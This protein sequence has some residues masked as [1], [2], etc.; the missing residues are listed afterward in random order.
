MTF[1]SFSVFNLYINKQRALEAIFVVMSKHA[2]LTF[3]TLI[4]V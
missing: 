2:T 4:M 3:M 1:C